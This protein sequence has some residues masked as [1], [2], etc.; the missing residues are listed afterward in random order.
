MKGF[1]NF[2]HR[3]RYMSSITCKTTAGPLDITNHH[4]PPPS[5]QAGFLH[6]A[7]EL[8]LVHF[9]ISIPVCF[10]YHLLHKHTTRE[11]VKRRTEEASQASLT[12]FVSK[13]CVGTDTFVYLNGVLLHSYVLYLQLFVREVLSQ[14]FGYSLQI[15]EWDLARLV[16]IE[17]A[18]SFQDFLLGVLLSLK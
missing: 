10:I 18:E 14:L 6:D 8:L 9:S 5:V 12:S 11:G 7:Q 15:F 17:Q 4:H 1:E 16:I 13:R 2:W 3:I